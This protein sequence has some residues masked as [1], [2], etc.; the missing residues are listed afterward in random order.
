MRLTICLRQGW[1]T[2][3]VG[4]G[5]AGVA[6]SSNAKDG[7]DQ[8]TGAGNKIISSTKYMG[9]DKDAK[10]VT[11]EF[12]IAVAP[13]SQ[14]HLRYQRSHSTHLSGEL[15]TVKGFDAWLRRNMF[16]R[17]LEYYLGCVDLKLC[18]ILKFKGDS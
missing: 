17:L 5:K 12:H 2:P 11:I 6:E 7:Y 16:V 3:T 1:S 13:G 18:N 15:C 8:A 9:K 4:S 10:E 14:S